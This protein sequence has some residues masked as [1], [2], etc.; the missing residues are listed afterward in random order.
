MGIADGSPPSSKG[1]SALSSRE[2][3]TEVM[4]E[5]FKVRSLAIFNS[6]VLAL[7]STGRTR[8]L[9]VESGEGVTHAV[10]IFEGYAIPHAIFKTEIAGQDI[11]AKLQEKMATD[12]N[13]GPFAGNYRVTQSMK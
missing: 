1:G 11:T 2:W 12:I 4:F 7:F 10:P 3:M 6:A 8:G 9:V 5:K 13:T